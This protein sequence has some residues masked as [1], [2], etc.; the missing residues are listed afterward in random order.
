MKNK[1]FEDPFLKILPTLDLHGE[2]RDTIRALILDFLKVETILGKYKVVIIHGRH[3]KV[4]REETH[5]ILKKCPYV[6]RF[7][8]YSFNDG[9]TIVELKTG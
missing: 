3:G 7:Y 4:L 6:D 2:T 9:L 1:Q 8:L 5:E